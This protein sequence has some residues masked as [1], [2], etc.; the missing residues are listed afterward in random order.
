[1]SVKIR[2]KR[3]GKTRNPHYRIVIADSRTHRDGRVIE[4]IGRYVPTA[5]PSVIEVNS[6][7]AQYW[8]GVGAQPTEQV[9]AILKLTGDLQA[10]RG[11]KASNKVQPQ[12]A[13]PEFVVSA[14]KPVTLQ[15]KDSKVKAEVPAVEAPAE[16]VE[17]PAVEAAEQQVEPEAPAEP[18]ANAEAA[19]D[20]AAE[21]EPTQAE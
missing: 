4:E 7:R 20:S 19:T 18:D 2:L 21:A 5:D 11:E 9:T 1:V 16:E 14:R 3:L 12:Q 15:P 6:E 8:L 13:K 17:A 10:S